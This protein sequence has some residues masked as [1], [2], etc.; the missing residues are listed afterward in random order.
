MP[1]SKLV[2]RPAKFKDRSGIDQVNRKSLP[3][4]YDLAKWAEMIGEKS[5]FVATLS[6]LVVGYVVATQ[7]QDP[8]GLAIVSIAVDPAHRRHGLGRKLLAACLNQARKDRYSQ[9]VLRVQTLNRPALELY[10]SMGFKA[11]ETMK[12]Y[13]YG[14]LAAGDHNYDAYLMC[15]D[16]SVIG[17]GSGSGSASG[18]GAGAALVPTGTSF[19]VPTGTSI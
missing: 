8:V 10:Q 18:S 15:C 3:V 5:S 16:L 7:S 12:D 13:Y 19:S 2:I 17:S 11:T 1:K 14:S 9:V 4:G 6:E